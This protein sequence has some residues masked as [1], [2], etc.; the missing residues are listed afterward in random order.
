MSERKRVFQ[1][2][3]PD[4]PKIYQTGPQN[5]EVEARHSVPSTTVTISQIASV[6]AILFF[7]FLLGLRNENNWFFV[8]IG[9]IAGPVIV[10]VFTRNI[11][12]S[13]RLLTDRTTRVFFNGATVTW[14]KD[15]IRADMERSFLTGVHS[16]ATAEALRFRNDPTA[17]PLYQISSEVIAA[18]G[19]DLG[20]HRV[21]AEIMQDH[22]Q[23]QGHLLA[24]ALRFVDGKAREAVG[25]AKMEATVR[26]L[27]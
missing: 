16:L 5:F 15:G 17:K 23:K 14:G 18:T 24:T 13:I 12:E 1:D 2:Q 21:I 27:D 9:L 26:S 19:P 22:N 6:V 25:K 10:Y 7:L 3:Y 20:H 11:L 4:W 8:L